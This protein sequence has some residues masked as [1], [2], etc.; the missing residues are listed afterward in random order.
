MLGSE[1][2]EALRFEEDDLL[3]GMTLAELVTAPL[4][5]WAEQLEESELEQPIP[6][7]SEDPTPPATSRPLRRRSGRTLNWTFEMPLHGAPAPTPEVDKT[8]GTP[9]VGPAPLDPPREDEGAAGPF[10]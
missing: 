10:A 1:R 7:P 6:L 5:R 3:G 4:P 8:L 2:E 9:S